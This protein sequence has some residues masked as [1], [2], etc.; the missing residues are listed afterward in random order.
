MDLVGLAAAVDLVPAA[1]EAEVEMA[2]EDFDKV[3]KQRLLLV[4]NHRHFDQ[5]L[6]ILDHT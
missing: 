1:L 2:S 4:D 5:S 6:L 3:R